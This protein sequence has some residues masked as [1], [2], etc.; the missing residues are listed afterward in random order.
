[1]IGGN[2]K[3]LDLKGFAVLS[4]SLGTNLIWHKFGIVSNLPLEV[5]VGADVLAPIFARS[6][7]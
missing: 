5:L 1:M 3:A 4:V 7:T 2:E 6:C